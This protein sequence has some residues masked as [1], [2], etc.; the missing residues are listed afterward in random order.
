MEYSRRLDLFRQGTADCTDVLASVLWRLTGDSD[1]FSEAMQY[2][3]LGIWQNVEKLDSEKAAAYIYKI[4]LSANSKAWRNRIGRNG[5]LDP[6]QQADSTDPAENF[7]SAESVS[8]VRKAITTLPRKQ[9]KAIVMRFLQQQ[10]YED[11]AKNLGC[12][13]AAARSNVSKALAALKSRLAAL[14]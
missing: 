12:S 10:S 9:A 2:A 1:L 11:I 3:L 13:E 8:L 4:A 6:D 7:A 14:K 5:D